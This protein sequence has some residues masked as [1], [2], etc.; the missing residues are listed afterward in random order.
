MITGSLI[1]MVYRPS[2]EIYNVPPERSPTSG[3]KVDTKPAASGAL[4]PAMNGPVAEQKGE[5]RHRDRRPM[6]PNGKAGPGSGGTQ[7]SA[8]AGNGKG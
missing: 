7:I 5:R 2:Q 3:A 6:N 4:P 8:E 1:L